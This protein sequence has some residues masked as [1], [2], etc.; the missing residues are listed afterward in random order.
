MSRNQTALCV[1]PPTRWG[2]ISWFDPQFIVIPV[3]G[4]IEP[5][6]GARHVRAKP[7][8]DDKGLR[9]VGLRFR[10]QQLGAKTRAGPHPGS[11]RS[12]RIW[13]SSGLGRRLVAGVL[14]GP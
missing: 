5:Q 11:Q 3:Y 2:F 12:L 13:I 4:G 7:I 9:S 10:G 14:A 1:S 8:S 6:S